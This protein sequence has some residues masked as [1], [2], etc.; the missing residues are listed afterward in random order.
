[1]SENNRM[2]PLEN[3]SGN[4]ISEQL[5]SKYDL[6]DIQFNH[7]KMM[8]GHEPD[9]TCLDTITERFIFC[10]PQEYKDERKFWRPYMLWKKDGKTYGAEITISLKTR[11][12]FYQEDAV[13]SISGYYTD[14]DNDEM[15]EAACKLIEQSLGEV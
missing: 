15:L 8:Q 9:A 2:H 11:K 1:M 4:F 7:D 5:K 6:D 13:S 12:F 3:V 10:K 14:L